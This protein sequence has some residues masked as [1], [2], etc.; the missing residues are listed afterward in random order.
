VPTFRSTAAARR[1]AAAFDAAAERDRAVDVDAY[2]DRQDL[3]ADLRPV[4]R[5][6]GVRISV[7]S[8]AHAAH[9][10][11][12]ARLGL[13]MASRPALPPTGS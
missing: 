11:R 6:G 7:G 8:D 3:D 2:V 13:A 9:Q 5:P 4:A 1:L 10:L 12:L